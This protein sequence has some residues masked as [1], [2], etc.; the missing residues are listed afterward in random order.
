MIVI[1]CGG[2]QYFLTPSDYAWLDELHAT[3]NITE[4][5]T[6]GAAGADTCGKQWAE[7]RWI[8]TVTFW[9]NWKKHGKSAGFKRNIRMRDYLMYTTEHHQTTCGVIG[10]S[11]GKGTAM[12]LALAREACIPV[13]LRT[14]DT[15]A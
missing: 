5:V 11:G 7:K 9:A 8:D 4:V 10:F 1:I 15:H 13:Y 2:I 3:H 12:M 14:D 6:G